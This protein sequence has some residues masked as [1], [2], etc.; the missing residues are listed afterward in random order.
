MRGI[1]GGGG[2]LR[3]FVG[4]RSG[5]FAIL[6]GVTVSMLAVAVG[7]GT[8]VAQIYNVR[9]NL[10]SSLDAALTSTGRDIS[11]GV[12]KEADAAASI[13]A[14][15]EANGDGSV[16]NGDY[17]IVLIEPLTIDKVEKTIE[18]TAYVDVDAFF[19]LFGQSNKTRVV[20]TA[21]TLYSDT[22]V[23]VA[24][25]LD[26]TGSMGS[27]G[28]RLDGKNQTKLQNLQTAASAA[29]TQLLSRNV[30]GIDPRVRVALVPYSQSVNVGQDLKDATYAEYDPKKE[31]G[32]LLDVVLNLLF[33]LLGLPN[34]IEAVGIDKSLPAGSQKLE[35]PVGLAALAKPLNVDLKK[36]LDQTRAKKGDLCTTER[37]RENSTKKIVFDDSEDGPEKAM[38]NR[39]RRLGFGADGTA[40]CPKATVVPLTTDVSKL[41][42]SISKFTAGGGTA[43]HIGI[44]WTRYM[45]S[46][47]W[48][49]FLSAKV[50]GSAPSKY[51]KDI[52]KIAILMTDG[53]FN[54]A[55]V[56]VAEG[57]STS[58]G[59]AGL[60]KTYALTLCDAMKADKIEV[61]TIGFMLNSGKST[62]QACA[63]PDTGALKHFYDAST[64]EELRQAFDEI[65]KNIEVLRLTN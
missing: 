4:D 21:A 37:K 52:K 19:P 39:D 43:G 29:V 55:Y 13:K 41:T 17:R 42:N 51:G 15:L 9:T 18:A 10:I 48:G 63:S 8:N 49:A 33:G 6:T 47:D 27:A 65:T 1:F 46:P 61:F 30:V 20:T 12:I 53:E 38:I 25:M 34:G 36:A 5:N 24:M 16:N 7:F 62:L 59:Q 28:T 45:L 11:T 57:G 64:G 60:S 50:T 35:R 2:I 23:E 40:G 56:G 32:G 22:K 3:R 54:A 58:G 31:P 44:Q 26:V 14:F